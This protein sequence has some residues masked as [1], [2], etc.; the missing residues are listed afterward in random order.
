MLV[1]FS[2]S[3]KSLR[4]L[5]L[6]WYYY[7]LK[8]LDL[9]DTIIFVLRKKDSQVSFLH[10]YHHAAIY[11]TSYFSTRFYPGGHTSMLGIINCYVHVAMYFYYFLTVLRPEFISMKWKKTLTL[12]QIL[13]FA[14]MVVHFSVP[15]FIYPACQYSKYWLSFTLAQNIFML[16]MF[17]DFYVRSYI[18]RKPSKKIN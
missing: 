11:I 16:V 2:G 14:A 6:T 17:S 10:I 7:M 1:D 8:L 18:I 5:H 3:P 4:A 13:Q 15:L 9:T 12:F